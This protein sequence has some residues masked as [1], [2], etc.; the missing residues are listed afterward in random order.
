M[1]VFLYVES[2]KQ[3]DANNRK[4]DT[5]C[6]LDPSLGRRYFQQ[7]L[8]KQTGDVVHISANEQLIIFQNCFGFCLVFAAERVKIAVLI[9]NASAGNIL[10]TSHRLMGPAV[11][12]EKVLLTKY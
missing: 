10:R 4:T 11:N 8:I 7:L 2:N 9:S 5:N 1:F 3:Y 6:T 12:S